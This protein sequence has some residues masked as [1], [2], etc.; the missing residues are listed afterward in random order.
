MNPTLYRILLGTSLFSLNTCWA[1]GFIDD[2]RVRLEARNFY[3]NGDFRDGA[4]VSKREE[5][6]QG[7]LMN[8]ESGFTRGSV[9]FGLDALAFAGFQLDS[10]PDRSASGLLP[11]RASGEA[12]GQ[13]AKAGGGLKFK[14][15]NT[16]V[17]YGMALPKVPVLQYNNSRLLPQTFQ[18]WQVSSTDVQH[19]NVNLA[20]FDQTIT[21]DSTNRQ[22]INLAVKDG[23][24][25]ATGIGDHFRYGGGSY[26]FD[27]HWVGSY[28]YGELTDVY[29]QQFLGLAYTTRV[30]RGGLLTDLRAF[31]SNEVGAAKAGEVDN[32]AYAAALSYTFDTGHSLMAAYQVMQGTTGFPY[33]NNPYLPNY[34]QYHDFGSAGERSWQVRYGYDFAPMGL[35]GLTFFTAYIK[36]DGLKKPGA[37]QE[38]ERDLDV[39][40]AFQAG[41]KGLSVR[42]R[43]AT[44]RSDEGRD[45]DE[46]RLIV[47]Y[48]F[49]AL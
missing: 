27:R 25:P 40:Y 21:P 30:G 45:M 13:Y 48:L 12:V 38:W 37:D 36:G 29:R 10:S 22:D 34:V 11:R 31:A 9:G 7:F 43:N 44:Y 49:N 46:N 26:T 5:W 33:I 42:W 1:E 39:A 32:R 2:S 14:V 20:Q 23:R 17:R 41:L 15:S 19:L 35:P 24:Y 4:G 47:S 6:A 8:Y 3:Y 28:Y 16:T 18:G